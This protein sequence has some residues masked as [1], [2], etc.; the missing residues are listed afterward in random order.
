ML[1]TIKKKQTTSPKNAINP[2]LKK[3]FFRQL[4]KLKKYF[5][6]MTLLYDKYLELAST[7]TCLII[8]SQHSMQDAERVYKESF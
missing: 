3:S 5:S 4:N 1:Y 6:Y 2:I 7:P 8:T